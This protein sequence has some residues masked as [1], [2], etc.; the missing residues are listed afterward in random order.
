MFVSTDNRIQPSYPI[1]FDK[2]LDR[3]FLTGLFCFFSLWSLQVK[4]WPKESYGRFY[5]GDSYIILHGEKDPR[6]NVCILRDEP[7]IFWGGGA[8]AI[9]KHFPPSR[10]CWKNIVQEEPLGKIEQGLSTIQVKKHSCASYCP[11]NTH[12]QP[13]VPENCLPP[14]R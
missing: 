3:G 12:T 11:Q 10:N 13:N 7:F 4:D 5:N 9:S 8:G 2:T 1:T 14:S 6:S